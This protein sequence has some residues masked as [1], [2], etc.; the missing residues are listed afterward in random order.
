M[1]SLHSL[2]LSLQ[3]HSKWIFLLWRCCK[4][5]HWLHNG[6]WPSF[7]PFVILFGVYWLTS[8]SCPSKG[9][10]L[11]GGNLSSLR[12]KKKE[13]TK[14]RLSHRKMRRR[15]TSRLRRQR[16]QRRRKCMQEKTRETALGFV[17]RIIIDERPWESRGQNRNK[18]SLTNNA[19]PWKRT[20][21]K[22]E[23]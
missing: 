21:Q 12:G 19:V 16:R 3:C 2:L 14:E 20:A 13:K 1:I 17:D 9:L 23:W 10:I 22:Q 11:F 8:S 18:S 5:E 7:L 6:R 4:V 15:I